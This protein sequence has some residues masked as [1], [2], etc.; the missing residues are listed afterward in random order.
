MAEL[1]NIQEVAMQFNNDVTA[2]NAEIR[3]VQSIKCRLKKQK[4][5]AE[6]DSKMTEILQREQVL[7]EARALVDPKEKPVTAYQQADVDELD[8]DETMKA[9]KSIQ[10]KKTLSRWL[11]TEEGNNDEYRNAC[12]IEA[13]L[14]EHKKLVKPVDDAYV[15]KTDLQTVIDT[16]ENSG[17]LDQETI[18]NMLKGLL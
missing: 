4:G 13:M 15:R 10:S 5:H 14:L 7:K 16:I 8:F 2:I 12:R 11:T 17:N 3:K 1:K 9:I 18:L 6:Y